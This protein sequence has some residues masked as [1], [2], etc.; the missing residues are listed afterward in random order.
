MSYKKHF[1]ATLEGLKHLKLKRHITNL[2]GLAAHDAR[3][4]AELRA[5]LEEIESLRAARLSA[6]FD[7]EAAA[8]KCRDCGEVWRV[9]NCGRSGGHVVEPLY[10]AAQIVQ[11]RNERDAAN[12]HIAELEGALKVAGGALQ[13]C[14]KAGSR[15]YV[16]LIT[17]EALTKISEVT[18]S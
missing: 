15:A 16:D 17:D 9:S 8:W 3:T 1:E 11:L 2:E 18:K 13:A 5:V 7:G 14:A 6:P 4:I 10:S 12:A